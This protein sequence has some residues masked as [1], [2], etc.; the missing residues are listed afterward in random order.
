M[1]HKSETGEHILFKRLD[2]LHDGVKPGY[3]IGHI[4]PLPTSIM[5]A[6]QALADTLFFFWGG[7]GING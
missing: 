3:I 4:T 5:R 7:G 6:V 1:Y 2:V